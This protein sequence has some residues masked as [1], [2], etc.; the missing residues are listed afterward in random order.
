MTP[1]TLEIV[2]PGE[3]RPP[4]EVAAVEVPA[5][6]GRLTVLAGHQPLVCT[7]RAGRVRVRDASGENR[8]WRVGAGTLT[9]DPGRATLLVAGAAEETAA[10]T[11]PPGPVTSSSTATPQAG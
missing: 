6:E 2:T 9:V 1:F 5:E 10:G 4:R 7:I 8:I 11:E 3:A